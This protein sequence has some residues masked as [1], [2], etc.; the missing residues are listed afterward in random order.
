MKTATLKTLEQSDNVSLYYICFDNNAESEYEAFV[1][2]Q[3]EKLVTNN[4]KRVALQ[5]ANGFFGGERK[6]LAQLL[7]LFEKV[8][9]G[10][11]QGL[12]ETASM[13]NVGQSDRIAYLHIL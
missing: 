1:Q 6:H 9:D 5:I 12:H 8:L 13:P 11:L 4:V 2:K 10:F 7:L 3:F